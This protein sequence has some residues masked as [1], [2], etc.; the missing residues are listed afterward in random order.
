MNITEMKVKEDATIKSFDK[1]DSNFRKRIMDLGIYE[2][3]H[4]ILL[5]KLSFGLL[6]LVEVDDVEICM[7][8]ED[9]MLI[10]VSR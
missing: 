5:S 10:E 6:Y 1:I 8:K 3:A 4:I 7:R 2:G 9:A